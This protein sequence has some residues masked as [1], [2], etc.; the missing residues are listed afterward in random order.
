MNNVYTVASSTLFVPQF[1]TKLTFWD[2]ISGAPNKAA[3]VIPSLVRLMNNIGGSVA[4]KPRLSMSVTH[5]VVL[6]GHD[7]NMPTQY[8]KIATDTILP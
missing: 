8:A 5:S 2:Q 3:G 4:T 7:I 6:C 1:D